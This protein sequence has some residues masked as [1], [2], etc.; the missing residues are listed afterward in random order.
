MAFS[1]AR[2]QVNFYATNYFE[3]FLN[4]VLNYFIVPLKTL[5]TIGNCQRLAFTV[6][7]SQHMHKLTNLRKFELD[8]S[9]ELRDNNERKNTLV[10]RSCV[11]SDA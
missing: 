2:Y 5:D 6:G 7:V 4:F 11:L 3:S 8:W 1:V 9:S 10:T